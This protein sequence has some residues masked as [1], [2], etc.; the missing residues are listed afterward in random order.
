MEKEN[1]RRNNNS[2]HHGSSSSSSKRVIVE[3]GV[4]MKHSK[5]L[6][7]SQWRKRFTVLSHTHLTLRCGEREES[8]VKHDVPV[9]AISSID[10]GKK[11]LSIC[12]TCDTRDFL[13]ACSK[14]S[15]F[16]RWV[17]AFRVVGC[18]CDER[19]FS[20]ST[21]RD[22]NTQKNEEKEEDE[23]A[24]N[25]REEKE[26]DDMEETNMKVTSNLL[27]SRRRFGPSLNVSSNAVLEDLLEASIKYAS[28]KEKDKE[29]KETQGWN[30]RYQHL[31]ESKGKI[32]YKEFS[33]KLYRL[34]YDMAKSATKHL[35]KFLENVPIS[36]H[37]PKS[38][39]VT[40]DH[41]WI[42]IVEGPFVV[43]EEEK[44]EVEG[45]EEDEVDVM[46]RR[47]IAGHELR[48]TEALQ[49]A[50]LR[51]QNKNEEDE[52]NMKANVLNQMIVDY[53]GY[54]AIVTAIPITQFGDDI[55]DRT[56]LKMLASELNVR[57]LRVCVC[58]CAS[59]SS[60]I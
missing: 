50:M 44:E 45:G 48:S 26:E 23:D 35:C 46:T 2:E 4:L 8:K 36:R 28:I 54:R 9:H 5:F 29:V 34:Q 57:Y 20:S 12:V 13:L 52:N 55:E 49:N 59:N 40:R 27:L 25:E 15:D 37:S 7:R 1:K 24:D 16:K 30:E 38:D 43:E 14:L 32:T 56:T 60:H 42:R 58:V 17:E 33:S 39:F 51:L 53:L 6:G 47:K 3:K 18:P 22:V 11:P 41:L 21:I 10:R 31:L 19:L